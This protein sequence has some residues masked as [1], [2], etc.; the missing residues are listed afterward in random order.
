M[1]SDGKMTYRPA[2][3][4]RQLRDDG[5]HGG[6][7]ALADGVPWDC[8]LGG[9][10]VEIVARFRLGEASRIG[11][12]VRRADDDSEVTAIYWQRHEE[13]LVVDTSRA[14][15]DPTTGGDVYHA[16]L[17]ARDELTLRVFLD[18][19]VLELFTDDRACLTSRIYPN[20]D[21]L[22]VRALASGGDAELLSFDIW[23][24]Q[25]IWSV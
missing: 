12:Q 4:V 25:S 8:P 2:D 13:R 6:G 24:M 11:M 10:T 22:G 21:S 14:S 1:G 5:W 20:P 9:D 19:S 15:A 16:E 7:I 18:R 17:S 23:P 3:E